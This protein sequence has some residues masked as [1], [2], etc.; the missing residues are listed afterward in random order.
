MTEQLGRAPKKQTAPYIPR[1][2]RW[3]A[4]TSHAQNHLLSQLHPRHPFERHPLTTS[5]GK[6]VLA[7]SGKDLLSASRAWRGIRFFLTIG[8]LGVGGLRMTNRRLHV[9]FPRG[10]TQEALD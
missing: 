7:E 4:V 1:H 2:P 8:P 3:R 6:D 5:T 9:Y 10:R